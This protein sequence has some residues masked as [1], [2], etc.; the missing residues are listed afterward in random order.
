MNVTDWLGRSLKNF[1]LSVHR[2]YGSKSVGFLDINYLIDCCNKQLLE[3]KKDF[4]CF[5]KL[6]K[7]ENI[8]VS[9]PLIKISS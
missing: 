8:V 5:D 1:N 3:K 4:C 2:A 6:Q 9:I 7:G